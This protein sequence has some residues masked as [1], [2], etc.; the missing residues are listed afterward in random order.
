VISVADT[1]MKSRC[2]FNERPVQLAHF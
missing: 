1:P 2:F